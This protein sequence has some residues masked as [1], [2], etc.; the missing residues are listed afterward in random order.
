MNKYLKPK[1]YIDFLLTKTKQLFPNLE[2]KGERIDIKYLE[3]NILLN[4]NEKCHLARYEF[5]LFEI[6]PLDNV[7]DFACGTGYGSVMLSKK[8][9]HV[10]GIDI[11][12]KVVEEIKKRYENI[13]NIE[14]LNLNLL[15]INYENNFD[16]IISFETIEHIEEKQILELLEKF[17]RALKKDG[18]LIFS[19]PYMQEKSEKALK[20]GFH[21]T[22]E[23]NEEKIKSWL[24]ETGFVVEYFRYQNYDSCKITKELENKDFII[25]I[26]TK[27]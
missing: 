22:F 15:D 7:G 3:K 27:Q 24:K 4:Q 14:F 9:K 21:L 19:T 18:K 5:S 25:C 26:A 10:T 23:I 8:A 1:K 13:K 2:S 20:M 16:K 12:A 11:D 17:H 6:S